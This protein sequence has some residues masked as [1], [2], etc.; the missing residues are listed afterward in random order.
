MNYPTLVQRFQ[1]YSSVVELEPAISCDALDMT[2]H[3]HSF[4]TS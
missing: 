2:G 4:Q 3:E 1:A